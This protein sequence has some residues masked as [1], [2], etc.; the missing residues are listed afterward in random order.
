[1]VHPVAEMLVSFLRPACEKVEIAGS[2]RR[3]KAEVGDIEIV[4][5]PTLEPIFGLFRL[6][7]T[8][9]N[10]LDPLLEELVAGKVVGRGERWGNRYKT[11]SIPELPGLKCDLFI[12]LPPAQWGVI[13]T[14]RTGPADFSRR[15]VTKRRYGGLL[16]SH[17]RI[18]D[19]ALWIGE[20][21]APTPTEQ[22][23]FEAIGLEWIPP[24]KR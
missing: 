20:E 2:L 19:G 13:F 14:I 16:P 18:K 4:I 9:R 23:F 8:Y 1:M 24:E 6:T 15:L 11:L 10:L 5:E 7:M 3:G 21:S 17:M 12:V 22:S